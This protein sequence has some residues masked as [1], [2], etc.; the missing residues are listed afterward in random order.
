[1]C[2]TGAATFQENYESCKRAPDLK[3]LS[4][5]GG[6]GFVP[7]TAD[8][9][10]SIAG[11]YDGIALDI[12]KYP[13]QDVQAVSDSLQAAKDAKPP[14][15]TMVTVAHSGYGL[16]ADFVKGVLSLPHVD[17][18]SPQLYTDTPCIQ[19]TESAGITW[20][21]W[22][23]AITADGATAKVL[24]SVPQGDFQTYASYDSITDTWCT[25]AFGETC[26][27]VMVW[28]TEGECDGKTRD[29]I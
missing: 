23:T 11:K 19:K 21:D 10:K 4:I 25:S 29:W 20:N 16:S 2:F 3:W 26:P 18:A 22:K 8:E 15:L 28:P 24:P 7:P 1:M 9:I 13:D 5:G 12:E 6:P 17:Y 27:G 14:L